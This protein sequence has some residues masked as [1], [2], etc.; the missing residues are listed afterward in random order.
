MAQ[1]I[2]IKR[3]TGTATPTSLENGELAYS[4]NSNKLFIGRPGGTT[5]DVDAIGGK[6]FTDKLDA[7]T[8]LNTASTL[9]QRD[10]S[11]DFSAGTITANL[12]GTADSAD[13]LS[14]ARDISL[15]GDL[16]G[17]ASFDGSSNI[18]ITA[19]IAANSVALG[20]DTTGNYIATLADAG[21]SNLVVSNSGDE[22]AAATI[23]L[24]DTAVTA[25]QYGSATEVPQ[26]TVDAKGRVTALSTN[27]ISTSFTIDADTGTPDTFNTGGTLTF[28]GGSG[29]STVVTNDTITINGSD[30]TTSTKGIASF[31]S[32]DFNVSSGSVSLA[33]TATANELNILDGA[34]VSTAEVNLLDGATA[35]TVINGKAVIYGSSGELAGTLST[36]AQPNVTS[37]GT[38]QGL[39]IDSTQTVDMGSN[40]VQSVS[41]PTDAQD[42]ATKAYVDARAEGLSTKPAVRA[43]T[44]ANLTATYDNGTSGVGATLTSTSNG[45][46]P[47]IDGVSGWSQFDG[48][49][50]KDQTNAGENGRYFV[51]TVGDAGTPWVLTRCGKCDENTEIPS[52]YVFV[53]EGT[54]Y[55]NTGWVASV[56]NLPMTVGTDDIDFIQFSGAGTFTAGDGLDLTGTSFSVNVDDSSIEISAD[57]LRVKASGIT[58]AMLAGSIDLTSKVTNTL[59]VANGGTGHASYTTGD[60]IYA[61]GATS[62]AKLG[63]GA[64]GNILTVAGGVPSWTD[65]LDGGTF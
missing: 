42:A 5:G 21:N 47:T 56:D 18:T 39:S 34:T 52:M 10:A 19:S 63:I 59:P 53:Q 51:S 23:D 48:I 4:S 64:T 24:S 37:L 1:T 3:S 62:I 32:D 8:N 13:T 27:S 17:S 57:T 28:T 65:T 12:S 11:G 15:G 26:I 43:A 45:A 16:S 60:L 33:T 14:V 29:I 2:K 31:D 9:V 46:F 44:T 7:A 20:I 55:G 38:L 22:S 49:L 30:A 25:G 50:V 41:D 35:N 6:V 61:N 36:A 58:N 54:L 40:R